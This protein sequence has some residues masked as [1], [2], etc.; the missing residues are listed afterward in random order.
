[1]TKSIRLALSLLALLL[2]H[3][4]H[5]GVAQTLQ[6]SMIWS[7]AAPV[8]TQAYV[9]FRKEFNL[10]EVPGGPALLHL[11][12][13]SRYLLWV[14]GSQILRG[15]SRFNPK[16]PEYDSLDIK[17]YLQTGANSLVV[18]VH[19]YAGATSGRIMS[20]A[21]GLTAL[22]EAGG[23]EILRSDT[24]WKS[25]NSTEYRPS[26]DAW[27][28]IPDVIDARLSPGAWTATDFDD[29][30]WTAAAPTDGNTWGALQTRHTP[31]PVEIELPGVKKLPGGE[32][33]SSILP[34]DLVPTS[35]P[36]TYAGGYSGHWMWSPAAASNVWFKTVWR[37][38]TFGSGAGCS[39][40]VLGDNSFTLYVNGSQIGQSADWQTGYTGNLNLNDG[41]VI[42]IDAQ[43]LENGDH[44]AG[45][46]AAV[47]RSGSTVLTTS[48]F[49]CTTTAPAAGWRTNVDLAGLA[50]PSPVNVHPA[51]QNATAAASIVLDLGK[52]AMAYP[53]IQLDADAGST[54]QI[55]YALRY[56]NGQPQEMYGTGTTYTAR[57]GQRQ[58]L[59][60][61]QWCARYVTLTCNSGR[62]RIL[63]LQ[64]IDRRYP[65]ERVGSFQ[66]SD[67]TLTNLWEM[68]VNTIEATTDDAHGSDARERNEW[69]QDGSKASF[70]TIRVAAAGP[71]GNGGRIYSDPRTL[72]KLLRDSAHSQLPD[73][74]MLGTFPTDRGDY[75]PHYVI[76]DYALQWLEALRWYHELTGDTAF[77]Q[78]MWPTL[79]AQMQWCLDRV[80]ARGLLNAREYTSFDNPVAYI[81]CEGANINAFFYQSL[82]D[83][84]YLAGVASQTTQAN[85]YTA[86]ADALFSAYNTQLWNASEQAYSAGY[87]SGS[88]LGPTVHAQLMALYSGLVPADRLAA[89]RAWFVANYKNPGAGLAV[90]AK[91]NYLDLIANKA[92]L[93]MPIMY[94]WAF[95]ELYRADTAAMDQE[96]ISEMRRRWT[97]MVNFLQD[98]GTL[99]ES[100][101]NEQG[102]GMSES[103]HNYGAIPAYFLS[104]FVLG[105]RVAGPHG[106]RQ[107]V[108]E[109]RPGDLTSASG[110]VV[111]DLG[112][113]P[114]SWTKNNGTLQFSCTV[115]PGETATLRLPV[116]GSAITLDGNVVNNLLIEGRHVVFPLSA[117]VHSLTAEPPPV[118][119][120]TIYE[121]TLIENNVPLNGTLPTTSSNFAG[122]AASAAWTAAATMS[123]TASGTTFPASAAA[124]LPVSIQPGYIYQLSAT[125]SA[126]TTWTAIGF[127]DSSASGQWHTTANKHAWALVRASG[128]GGP[129]FF[130]GAGAAN[131]Q[132]WSTSADG[133]RTVL[134]TLDTTGTQ[135]TAFA[136][137]DGVHSSVFT[138]SANPSISHIGFGRDSGGSSVVRD[139]Y[140]TAA[141][142]PPPYI[143]T[144]GPIT[145]RTTVEVPGSGALFQETL[146]GRT[147]FFKTGGGMLTLSDPANHSGAT[148]ILAGTLKLSPATNILPP[149]TSLSLEGSSCVLD[150]NGA[151]QTVASLGSVSGSVIQLNGGTL[152]IS[153]NTGDAIVQGTITG[154]GNLTNSG[155][156]RLVGDATLDFTGT[157]TNTGVLDIMTW[158]GTLP[159]GFVNSG[160]VLDRSAVKITSH[161]I[162]GND[163]SLTIQGHAGHNYQL[164]RC[165]SLSDAWQN[166]GPAQPGGNA[167]LVFTD[168]GGASADR[169]FY[170]IS[171]AP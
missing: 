114:V 145:G 55:Q 28:S 59:A 17:P 36:K 72:R 102:G 14:N 146:A 93:D 137:I 123:Q 84:A 152:I 26:P 58:L 160:I 12:A 111:T 99:S 77:V 135:W 24:S 27:S 103:C 53:K 74:R 44:T 4:L 118:T 132:S 128:A 79:V 138:F 29:S 41:D 43:D 20:H 155:T 1:M 151:T 15:P 2:A 86:A 33:V 57:A 158:Q 40:K 81:T 90:G 101:V 110:T 32:A 154:T 47:V 54:F 119:T 134:I 71:D 8:G 122:G 22:L 116:V 167:T 66:C 124:F 16:G 166:L 85:A 91:S 109:P 37:N 107:L 51:H 121:D 164:Q 98:A 18:L 82:R 117:G 100:F 112:P 126:A 35:A 73:G 169:R 92:G 56:V 156:L 104:S 5:A 161:A 38:S 96:A 139:F 113:V 46:F 141:G 140:L 62:V 50:A 127:S 120:R 142:T 6:S 170:R 9:A 61:D 48:D 83:A 67:P 7:P 171:I 78:E 162:T 95:S 165:D 157:F 30:A 148:R 130:G 80:T 163:F 39:I 52:M 25:S 11:F 63:G 129:Q 3:P 159:V 97:N 125:L 131:L 89:T 31:L 69:V 149:A 64:M 144:D 105:P 13:D 106:N 42:T 147:D 168:P 34:I 19:H 65:Y 88:K 153:G 23:E 136:T 115:P 70:N 133:T 143:R 108:I 45:L 75:D 21:P 49:L 10:A 76:E 150:L 94:Y 60:A 68:A 87:L